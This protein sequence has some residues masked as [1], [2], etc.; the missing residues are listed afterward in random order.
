MIEDR[1]IEDEVI[2]SN[3]KF[4]YKDED[5]VFITECIPEEA[6]AKIHEETCQEN[7]YTHDFAS[8]QSFRNK[9]YFYYKDS[10]RIDIANCLQSD[11]SMS[12]QQKADDCEVIPKL[13]FKK[14]KY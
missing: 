8:N 6:D 11:E 7:P 5:Q 10:Q 1:I 9:N 4:T 3:R 12:H 2:I 13:I 14:G